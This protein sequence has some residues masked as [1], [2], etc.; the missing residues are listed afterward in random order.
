[1]AEPISELPFL[2]FIFFYF[3]LLRLDCHMNTIITHNDK[4]AGMDIESFEML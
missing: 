4:G 2:F 3:Q 1:M